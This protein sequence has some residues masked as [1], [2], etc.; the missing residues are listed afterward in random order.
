MYLSYTDDMGDLVD[1]DSRDKYG[2]VEGDLDL[3][4]S[5]Y[6]RG[7]V[8]SA[9]IGIFI[10]VCN[11][12]IALLLISLVLVA[13]ATRTQFVFQQVLNLAFSDLCYSVIVDP[14]TVYF[15]LQSWQLSSGFCVTYMVAD[16]VL[17]CVSFLVL[18]VLN[19][20]RILFSLSPAMYHRCFRR[21]WART[22]MFL[23]PWLAG[24][25]VIVPLWLLTA[26]TWP[27]PG[28]CIYGINMTAAIAS[29]VLS[30]YL[31][32]IILVVITVLNFVTLIGGMPEDFNDLPLRTGPGAVGGPVAG[33]TGGGAENKRP[34]VAARCSRLSPVEK[35]AL[36]RGHRSLVVAVCV[37]NIVSIITQL[38]F[39]AISMLEPQCV[40]AGCQSTVK[41]LQAL[42]WLRSATFTLRPLLF[43]LLTQQLRRTCCDLRNTGCDSSNPYCQASSPG[44]N[45]QTE[46]LE[47]GS[48][49]NSVVLGNSA[50]C[51]GT[52]V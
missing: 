27:R 30:L 26:T 31:P 51:A 3:H 34:L 2:E 50:K 22:A 16:N 10:T 45:T 6:E 43:I 14:F 38:P 13:R 46:R 37:A 35:V 24:C 33:Y 52:M 5:S 36:R 8:H 39:G 28:M 20:D 23:T 32:S 41:L 12:L 25:G 47:L 9:N 18:V 19:S 44:P 48:T 40:E 42:S 15:E 4:N 11:I 7:F 29:A 21:R 1:E 49:S 17:P